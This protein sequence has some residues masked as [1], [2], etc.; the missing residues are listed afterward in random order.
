MSYFLWLNAYDT[1]GEGYLFRRPR[2]ILTFEGEE[3]EEFFREIEKAVKAG[4]YLAGFLTYEF[5]YHLEEKLKPYRER[6]PEAVPLAWFGVFE[7]PE[8]FKIKTSPGGTG[9]R[10][11]DLTL[12]LSP[13]AYQE[14]ISRIKSYIASGDTYQ[15]NYTLKYHFRFEGA[16]R[17][18]FFRLLR[19]Q[20]VRYACLFETPNFSV[21][22]LSPELFLQRKGS[23][24]RSSPM[25]GTAP[26]GR[27]PEEDREIA[28]WLS[29]DRKNRAENIMIVDLI[30]NDLGRICEKGSVWVPELFKVERYRTVHQMISTVEGR[31][32]E[33]TA[34]HEI[35]KALF[36]CGSV[37][38]APKIRTMEIIAELEAEPRGVYTGA[39]GFIKP[40]GDFVFNVAIRTVVLKGNRGEFGIGSGIVWDSDPEEEYRECLLKARFLT[41]DPPEFAL[42]ET[43]RFEPGQGFIRLERHLARLKRSA[44]YFTL[45][46]PENRLREGLQKLERK[47][48]ERTRVRLLLSEWGEVCL[49]T[50]PLKDF[51]RPIRVGLKRR[52][53]SPDSPFLFHKTTH[54]PWYEEAR[55]EAERLGVTEIVFFDEKGRLTEG[56]ISN[57]FLEIDGRLYTPPLSLGLLP[58]IL[59]ETLLETGRCREKEIHLSDLWRGRLY[60]GNSVR[61]LIPV[62][63]VEFLFKSF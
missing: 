15:V 14:A 26:R 30:R 2:K 21:L 19:K 38:G 59:R 35:I 3:P 10:L 43:L 45:P 9:V 63:V 60:L 11:S 24:L 41:E 58:G 55:R 20:R 34:F 8:P 50:G 13:E 51:S 62:E 39:L 52:T 37:T 54:R 48:S 47:L 32:R 12:N 31:L 16:P 28:R 61:G 18:L 29:E 44:A 33:G 46:F 40:N 6:R 49:E 4:F 23:I 25:K 7:T 22:S 36:P 17:E 5:G 57:V 42:L 53:F 56:T 1:E 27:F